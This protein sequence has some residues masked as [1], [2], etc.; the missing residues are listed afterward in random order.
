VELQAS[1]EVSRT[2]GAGGGLDLTVFGVGAK[3]E[4]SGDRSRGTAA[5]VKVTLTPSDRRS[6]GKYQI[7]AVDV[8]PPPRRADIAPADELPQRPVSSRPQQGP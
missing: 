3:G 6:G 7:S 8:E 1:L 2:R 5:T 4:L